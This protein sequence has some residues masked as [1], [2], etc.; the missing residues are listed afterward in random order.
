MTLWQ[1]M[2]V[3]SFSATYPAVLAGPKAGDDHRKDFSAIKT[4][5]EWDKRDYQ[6]GLLI[7]LTKS[8]QD[9]VMALQG[10]I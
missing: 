7:T 2:V 3:A 4:L 1:S 9:E 5:E 8:M 6:H 10:Y